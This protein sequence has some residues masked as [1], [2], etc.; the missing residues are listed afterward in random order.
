MAVSYVSRSELERLRAKA[1]EEPLGTAERDER[2]RLKELSDT[3]A[4]AWPNTIQAQRARKERARLE[5]MAAEEAERIQIDKQEAALRAEDRRLQIERANKILF[6]ESDRVRGLHSAL[7]KC[8]VL[9]DNETLIG[10]KKQIGVLR[11]AQDAAFVE[12]QRQALDIAEQAELAK[13]AAERERALKQ[14]DVQLQQVEDFRTRIIA[15]RVESKREGELLKARAKEEELELKVKEA[16]R[17]RKAQELSAQVTE[18]NR[19]LQAFKMKELEKAREADIAM[20]EYARKKAEVMAERERRLAEKRAAK[21][22]ERKK[23]ADQIEKNFTNWMAKEQSRLDRDVR[24]AE[25]KAAEDEA[26]RKLRLKNTLA[27]I[28]KTNQAQ[29]AAK[30]QAKVRVREE[31]ATAASE[32]TLRLEELKQ[33]ER[34]EALAKLQSCKQVKSFQLRQAEMRARRAAREKIEAL[35]DAAQMELTIKEQENVFQQYAAEWVSEYRRQGKTVVPITH[36]LNKKETLE[37]M[38]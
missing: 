22:A 11:K 27:D 4:A 33:E 12:Q 16:E 6:D 35:Q 3:R 38:R 23:I 30:A 2:R 25:I 21:D 10:F 36:Y 37:T 7:Q 13:L 9:Q 14:R 31:E 34:A 1:T 15:E 32:W 8:D 20:E 5:R 29:L 24:E 19:T 26:A 28:H 18:A 17:R